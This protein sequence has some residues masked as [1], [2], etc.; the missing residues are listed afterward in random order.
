[1]VPD[2]VRKLVASVRHAYT[3]PPIA[4]RVQAGDGDHFGYLEKSG[5]GYR[6]TLAKDSPETMLHT[7]LHELA[8]AVHWARQDAGL[9]LD[10]AEHGDEFWLI[11]GALYRKYIEP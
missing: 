11:H 4:L 5:R 2:K 8:H 6:I 1:M 3:L 9:S 10:T 7:C